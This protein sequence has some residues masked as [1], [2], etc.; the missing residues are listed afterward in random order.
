MSKR[1]VKTIKQLVWF[2]TEEAKRNQ[3]TW[4]PIWFLFV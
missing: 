4:S 2:A 1:K 3:R